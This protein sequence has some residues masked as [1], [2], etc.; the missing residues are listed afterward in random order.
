MPTPSPFDS[1]RGV[2]REY[3]GSEVRLAFK[4][5]TLTVGTSAVA[6]GTQANQ[7]VAVYFGNPGANAIIIGLSASV[8]ATSGMVVG[9]SGN[10]RFD[11]VN[12]GELVMA[13]FY[14]ISSQAA[15]TLYICECILSVV[16]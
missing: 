11:W 9:A 15:Q 1:V 7:R 4:E 6:A 2:I 13:Q 5:T 16:S 12:D 3:Y 8:S 10:L 14:A